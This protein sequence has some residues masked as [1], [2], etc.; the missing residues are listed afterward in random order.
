MSLFMV[1]S[2]ETIATSAAAE[3]TMVSLT[4]GDIVFT[5]PE[6]ISQQQQ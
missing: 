6:T 5:T 4:D 3:K 2:P 1:E